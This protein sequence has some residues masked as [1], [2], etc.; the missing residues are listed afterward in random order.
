[1]ELKDFVAPL[2]RWWWLILAATIIAAASSFFAVSQQAPIYRA[3]T[4]LLVG[5]AISDP[6]PSGAEFWLTQQLATTY[7]DIAQRDVV[8]NAVMEKLGLSWLP[9]YS[10]DAVPNTQLIEITVND[11]SPERAMVVANELAN[12]LILQTPTNSQE[13]G[14]LARQ[15]FISSQLDELELKIDETNELL[16][17]KQ[18]ELASLVSA[19]Q[20]ADAQGQI[21]AL[22]NKLVT[23]QSNYASLLASTTAGAANSLRVIE[24]ATMPEMPI[25][26]EKVMT[27]VTAAA[28][29]LALAVG[30]AYLLEYLDDTVKA[31]DDGEQLV[32]LP[33]L[34]GITAHSNNAG[35]DY[36]LIAR[37]Q[38][39]SPVSEAYRSLRTGI[40]FANVDR[41]VGTLLITSANPEEGKSLT[42][43][44][45]GVVMAQAGNRVL[46]VDADLRRPVQ[47]R[48]FGLRSNEQGLTSMLL[49]MIVQH[50][51]RSATETVVDL[52]EG[53]IHETQQE[54]LFL[55][56]SGPKPPNPAELVGS[57]K[58]TQLLEV[59]SKLYDIVIVDSPPIL[60]VTDSIVLST[61][62]DGVV[63]IASA[64]STR[65]NQLEQAVNQLRGVNANVL[66]LVLNRISAKTG[67]YYYSYYYGRPYYR[68]DGEPGDGSTGGETGRRRKSSRPNQRWLPN[69]F[70]RSSKG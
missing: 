32:G 16:L 45:L 5:S 8:R 34:A 2:Q 46:L 68:D 7:T 31:P 64:G 9:V 47:H 10:A 17:T 18:G 39:R 56:N 60:A 36:S 41:P 54:G 23:L 61:R 63:M 28:I 13:N 70:A 69:F 57:A 35:G 1:M 51:A 4:T 42:A 52:M 43:A 33:M 27:V 53:S 40:L 38:P 6:N 21:G 44:N 19:R 25:G 65:R 11:S 22:E 14:E 24:P 26:P 50:D 30:A 59:L 3:H 20:I 12:Q 66:G 29:G 37:A 55:L 62:V 49:A 15:S 58:M 67:G 48:V